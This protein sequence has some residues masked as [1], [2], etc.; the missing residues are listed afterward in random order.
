MLSSFSFKF[1]YFLIK[2]NVI[3]IRYPANIIDIF[4]E[5]RKM[6]SECVISLLPIRNKDS[7][8][9]NQINQR[10]S[11]EIFI[12][13]ANIYLVIFR[14]LCWYPTY[15]EHSSREKFF[16]SHLHWICFVPNCLFV[17]IIAK[18]TSIKTVYL[19]DRRSAK[20]SSQRD[21]PKTNDGKRVTIPMIS[22][23]LDLK[24]EKTT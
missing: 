7:L 9:T 11:A 4:L 16:S 5:E 2:R 10:T 3:C 21:A 18:S 1:R 19:Y 6:S 23:Y 20:L 14:E 13:S 8:V 22:I 15:N 17:T 12:Q 24:Q